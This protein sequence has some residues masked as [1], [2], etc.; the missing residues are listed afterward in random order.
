MAGLR[1]KQKEQRR[2]DILSAAA[3]LFLRKGYENSTVNE[4][5][6]LAGVSN[7][8]VFNY[9][10]TKGE[11]LLALI[12][13]EN[14]ELRKQIKRIIDDDGR[15]PL[16][17]VCSFFQLVWVESLKS[18][19]RGSWKNVIATS[20]TNADS[21]FALEYT[22]LRNDLKAQLGALLRRLVEEGR[23]EPGHDVD[24]IKELAYAYH[25]Q[26][27]IETLSHEERTVETYRT[28]L[29]RGMDALIGPLVLD[30]R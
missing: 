29:R 20:I 15:G 13:Q 22:S 2:R 24:A 11:L 18:V 8:T 10:E 3:T 28:D 17:R 14:A 30:A 19:D 25:Y 26:L 9:Y 6:A 21:K 27:F 7:V 16:E 4:V 1:Q 12:A 5:A 23:L